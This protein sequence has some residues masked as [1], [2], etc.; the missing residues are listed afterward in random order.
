MTPQDLT[1]ITKAIKTHR[2]HHYVL[3]KRADAK[4]REYS[5]AK[6]AELL[7]EKH[8]NEVSMCDAFMSKVIQESSLKRRK[9]S[10]F[11]NI[12]ELKQIEETLKYGVYNMKQMAID[13]GVSYTTIQK[14]RKELSKITR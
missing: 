4:K 13:Y 2:R 8:L 12:V 10:K 6:N 1:I 11:L 5:H 14:I 7:K 3:Y 9:T